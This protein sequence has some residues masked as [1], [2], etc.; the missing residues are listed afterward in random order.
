MGRPPISRSFRVFLL[1]TAALTVVLLLLLSTGRLDSQPPVLDW[2]AYDS[3]TPVAGELVL[4]LIV[5]DERP[6]IGAVTAQLGDL[7]PV[8]ATVLAAGSGGGATHEIRF[9]TSLVPD[10][11]QELVVSATDRSVLRNRQALY[12]LALVDN[13]APSIELAEA[14]S[15]GRQGVTL[16]LFVEASEKLRTLTASFVERDASFYPI[17]DGRRFRALAGIGVQEES[18]EITLT[19]VDRAGNTTTVVS[20]VSIEGV[21][22]P[23]GGYVNLSSRQQKDQKDR[24]KGQEA[25]A[26]RGEAYDHIED[27][28][29]WS[30]AFDRPAEGLVTSPFGKFRE[31]SSGVKRHH[32]G[33]DIANATGTPIRA[34]AAG[35]VTL[36]EELHI[37]GKV[38][39][40]SHGQQVSSSYN[41]LHTIEVEVGDH[42]ERGQV[43]GRMGSTGQSTGSHLH[44][45]MV[46]NGIAVDPA[47]W[48]TS[49]FGVE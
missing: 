46:A 32:L 14:S 31:Y 33:I 2:V 24:T 22:W 8:A 23:R 47:E 9:D 13:T 10:G 5:S 17:G 39:I 19:A 11:P 45:G 18:F 28:Q 20:E 21:D 7:E 43:I 44:W 15:K 6:G 29:L 4:Q 41:H 40:L 49:D 48:M 1:C 26:K 35:V 25:N 38:V 37:Y 42:V 34:P 27:A 16:P 3:T 36:A 12:D 30:G